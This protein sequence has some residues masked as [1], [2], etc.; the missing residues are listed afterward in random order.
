MKMPRQPFTRERN[1]EYLGRDSDFYGSEPFKFANDDFE[2]QIRGITMVK[3][4]I[5]WKPFR[6]VFQRLFECGITKF[7]PISP[8]ANLM[9]EGEIEYYDKS[10][11]DNVVMSLHLLSAGFY[12]WLTC[13]LISLIALFAEIITHYIQKSK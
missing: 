7:K 9:V 6:E 8:A 4:D 10:N 2:S 5:Y 13:V 1:I 11:H 3:N 12:V